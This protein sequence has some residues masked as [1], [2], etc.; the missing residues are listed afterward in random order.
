MRPP[1]PEAGL[2]DPQEYTKNQRSHVVALVDGAN[3]AINAAGSNL[4]ELQAG[5]LASRQLDNPPDVIKG[6]TW[7]VWFIQDGIGGREMLFDTFY[8]FGDEGAPDLTLKL[9][10]ELSI[11]SC[12]A[13]SATKI[14]CSA[15]GF[16]V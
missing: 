5:A 2:N 9:A 3:V 12:V 16:G 7:Q 1:I 4:F 6:M 10:N 11:I 13:T 15:N 8:D 14:R